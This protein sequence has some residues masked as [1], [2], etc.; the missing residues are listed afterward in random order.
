MEQL[1]FQKII[2]K[3]SLKTNMVSLYRKKVHSQ[4]VCQVF[5]HRELNWIV[6]CSSDDITSLAII[7]AQSRKLIRSIGVPKGIQT[8]EFCKRPSYLLTGGKDGIM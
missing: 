3:D 8:F 7:S 2:K 6:S 4:W 5:F 1:T